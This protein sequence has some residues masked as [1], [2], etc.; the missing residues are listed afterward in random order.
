MKRFSIL[1]I[2]AWL[3]PV[4]LVIWISIRLIVPGSSVA[5]VF[6]QS[7][8]GDVLKGFSDA[9]YF[10]EVRGVGNQARRDMIANGARFTLSPWRPFTGVK[11][12]FAFENPRARIDILGVG[13]PNREDIR[14]TLYAPAFAEYADWD[15]VREGDMVLL[16][17]EPQ[18]GSI[19]EFTTS[20]PPG[21][22]VM[23]LNTT[24]GNPSLPADTEDG[25]ARHMN[26]S[27][28][29]THTFYAYIEN[30]PLDISFSKQDANLKNGPDRITAFVYN[31]AGERLFAETLQDDG[32]E[33]QS[34]RRGPG[35][36]MHIFLDGIPTGIYRL[37]LEA[38][39]DVVITS[40]AA[41][42]SQ[43]VLT[44]VLR[45][46]SAEPISLSL[47]GF[48]MNIQ[49]ADTKSAVVTINEKDET[50]PAGGK[51]HFVFSDAEQSI[52]FASQKLTLTS[53]GEF[54]LDS[55]NHFVPR[56]SLPLLERNVADA[57]DIKYLYAEY[58]EPEKTS[59]GVFLTGATFPLN[60]LVQTDAGYR[61]VLLTDDE[62]AL[63]LT[64]GD[65][66]LTLTKPPITA[67]G[68]VNKVKDILKN[69]FSS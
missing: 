17:R 63:P 39:S 64:F 29:G 55:F 30:E 62:T 35:Q 28:L 12:G 36:T 14:R 51:R 4:A 45:A 47:V 53:E 20:P 67:E 5:V 18:Y 43:L 6:H 57:Y 9:M 21:N 27:L 46:E 31:Q 37:V 61:F 60:S 56:F 24:L 25:D 13:L 26:I 19:A 54:V 23:L 42:T 38:N 59:D 50:I 16:Q 65:V 33:T 15:V 44:D 41:S 66:S 48:S 34:T 68:I 3:L 40:I 32:D 52:T 58:R 11:L 1:R 49:N 10:S 22:E 8:I 69:W 7:A 2:V